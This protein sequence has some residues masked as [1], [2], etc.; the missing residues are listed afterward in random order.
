MKLTKET[1]K[2][3]VPISIGGR[4]LRAAVVASFFLL[5]CSQ[6]NLSLNW[7][8]GSSVIANVGAS[9]GLNNIY[10]QQALSIIQQ[11]CTSCHGSSSGPNGVYDL[12]DPGN[13]I[14]S[15]LV[16]LGLPGQSLLYT[17][18][19]GGAMP[20]SGALSSGQQQ[21]ISQWITA[22]GAAT[23][24]PT[25]T[26]IPGGPISFATLESAIFQP[27]CVSCHST[28]NTSGST[29]AF[30]TY[31]NVTAAVDVA[32]PTQSILYTDTQSGT[33]PQGGPALS[34]SDI[35]AILQWIQEGAPNN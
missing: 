4:S 16:T 22:A 14:S 26:P 24:T 11:N 33:M 19:S 1:A 34:A 30:D 35:S 6:G 18:I 3:A 25:P 31:S 27:K 5:S 21:I 23:P 10:E 17:E 15:G 9:S 28:G 29:Y 12:T 20:P 13:L 8:G 7:Q 2:S 32:D